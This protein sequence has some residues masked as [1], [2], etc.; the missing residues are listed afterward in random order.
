LVVSKSGLNTI[1]EKEETSE[2]LINST[3]HGSSAVSKK[4]GVGTSFST[5][6]VSYIAGEL[7]KLYPDEDINLIRGLVAQGARLPNGLM[8]NPT[9]NSIKLY[10]YG[11]PSLDR[12][13]RNT[14][15]RITFYNSGEICAKEGHIYSLKIPQALQNPADDFDIMIEVTLTYTASVR[16]TRQKTKSYLSTWLDWT[17]SKLDDDFVT[18]QKRTIKEIKDGKITPFEESSSDVIQWMIREQ[19]NWGQVEELNRNSGTLQKDWAIIKSYQL[20]EELCFSIR[21]HN[22]WGKNNEDIPYSFIVSIEA[23]NSNLPIYESI[24]IENEVELE[25]ET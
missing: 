22:G 18:F 19:A 7:L 4:S 20:P 2:E 21:G 24:K 5:P 10:G 23:I 8:R 6:K 3:L 14:E 11:I 16:R 25:S 12:V 15:Q 9:A 13:T 1:S 17:S